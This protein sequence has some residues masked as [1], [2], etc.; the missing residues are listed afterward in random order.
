MTANWLAYLPY[1]T[2]A[3]L[4]TQPSDDPIG[5]EQRFDAVCLFADITGFTAISEALARNG[6]AGTEELIAI[7]NGYFEPMIDLIR[8][9]GGSVGKFGGDAVTVVFR[10]DDG[11]AA[12]RALSCA[13][14]IQTN[15]RRSMTINTSV[16][17]FRLAVKIGIARGN[18]L[19]TT[20]GVPGVRLEPV[21]AG[22]ALDQCAEAEHHASRGEIVVAADALPD[23]YEIDTVDERDGFHIIADMQPRAPRQPLPELPEPDD[24]AAAQ[25]ALFLHPAIAERIANELEGFISE[26]RR[27]TVL[28][29]RFEGF[30]YD[31]DPEVSARLVAYFAQ[32]I[33]IVQRYDGYLNKID[34]GD[35]G[36][37]YI[38]LFGAPITHEN[39][40]T[41]ALRC[42]LELGALDVPTQ[43]G[44]NTGLVYSGR[45]GS[46]RRQEYTVMGDAVN[47]AARLMQAA[48]K[49]DHRVLVSGETRRGAGDGAV[50]VTLEPIRVKGKTD[51]VAVYQLDGWK[52]ASDVGLR[53]PVYELPMIGRGAALDQLNALLAESRAGRGQIVSLFAEAGLGKSR[54]AAAFIAGADVQGF[55]GE[56]ESYGTAMP[57]L[58]WQNI[59]RGFF[60][61][62]ADM[63]PETIANTLT[64]RLNAIDTAL[65]ERLPLLAA[66]L[67]LVIEDN[68]FTRAL[69][70]DLRA[71]LTHAL[72]LRCL[73]ARTE[74][75]L[76]VLEDVHWIDPS[77]SALLDYLARGIGDLPVMILMLS[78]PLDGQLTPDY[79]ALPHHT[80]LRLDTFLPEE[81]A[82][83][84]RLKLRQL[85]TEDT[86]EEIP[87]PPADLVNQIV[88]RAEGNPFYIEE[89]INYLRDRR[90]DPRTTPVSQFELP[91]SLRSLILSRLDQLLEGEKITARVASVVGR[92]FR[93]RWLWG[94]YPQLGTPDYVEQALGVLRQVDVTLLDRA[95]P[96]LEY[97]F[98]H[99]TTWEVVYESITHETRAR[100]HELVADFI[101]GNYTVSLPAYYDI[102][103]YHYGSS[104]NR[105]K[106]RIYFRAAGDAARK[107]Y[108]NAAA[109][110]YYDR[111]LPLLG[112]A[113][114]V[115]VLLAR[116]A[117][118]QLTGAWAE[119]EADYRRALAITQEREDPLA[120]ARCEDALGYLYVFSGNNDDARRLLTSARAR[121]AVDDAGL[122][123]VLEHLIYFY[124]QISDLDTARTEAQALL[125]FAQA[126]GDAQAEMIA[127]RGLGLVAL[128]SGDLE[129]AET[130]LNAQIAAARSLDNRQELIYALNNLSG[131]RL[132]SDDYLH[133]LE[134][135]HEA[136]EIAENIGYRRAAG[137]IIGNMGEVYR[138][139]GDTTNARRCYLHALDAAAELNDQTD[140]TLAAVGNLAAIS[141]RSE[142]E[143]L[144]PRAITFARRI[145]NLYGLCE[146]LYRAGLISEDRALLE[147]AQRTANEIGRGD[148]AFAASV[149][150]DQLEGDG[151]SLTA[152]LDETPEDAPDQRADILYALWRIDGN[153]DRASEA[154]A[155]YEALYTQTYRAEYRLRH[156][157]LTR[158]ILPDPPPLPA[159]P[160][161]LVDTVNVDALLARL[162]I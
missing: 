85:F 29:C 35:K 122:A 28:F 2:A 14:D 50:W 6:S 139:R 72:L 22:E 99:L 58:V 40:E 136:Y 128:D 38:I 57:Y 79:A 45:V 121:F 21:I 155:L 41:R 129:A 4:L 142:A 138:E 39:D 147:E 92:L 63:P 120:Q 26:H 124:Q 150:L 103:A 131:V 102:L 114:Q 144:Y 117:V 16:G 111:L 151:T 55:S 54:L 8:L 135:M 152:L 88:D 97:L 24:A 157:E 10:N 90:I 101:E 71:E 9:Y 148:M 23:G 53:V 69:P 118:Y 34:M 127:R 146:F 137:A 107:A 161:G 47:L 95:Q 15:T 64:E 83:L 20:V 108:A 104:P 115:E 61:V 98:K 123:S 62:D 80:D 32:V 1:H 143:T 91:N 30:D 132:F 140:N 158:Q 153:A 145:E 106:Q 67:N 73:R 11:T 7:L 134:L 51:P 3:D 87:E 86:D 78:R 156:A 46:E 49:G 70:P 93:A 36:S 65:V 89:V 116:G 52:A 76:L 125:A 160:V 33:E 130:H 84:V 141:A 56:C 119:A 96:E 18:I 112:E 17:V 126:R 12:A 82:E 74:P 48:V 66:P 81:A 154:A 59:W 37:K 60:G 77:S 94:A 5:R 68:D 13:L 113:D 19:M 25:M 42:A 133:A 43:I 110:Q 109:L 100:I 162:N 44:V 75:L 149:L 105:A 27:V 159:P 31:H